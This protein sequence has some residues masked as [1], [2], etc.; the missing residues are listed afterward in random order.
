MDRIRINKND[1]PICFGFNGLKELEGLTGLNF[2]ASVNRDKLTLTVIIKMV[3]VGLLEGARKSGK[4]IDI[5][6]ENVADWLDNS[7]GLIP[8]VIEIFVKSMPDLE[9]KN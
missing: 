7:P 8:E 5:T 6:Q 4:D 3:Y 1:Y 9:K 2:L